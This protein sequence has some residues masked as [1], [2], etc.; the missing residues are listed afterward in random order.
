MGLL[1]PSS[2]SQG[3]P[4]QN[5]AG[6]EERATR[7]SRQP[8]RTSLAGNQI[9]SDF[10]ACCP[11]SPANAA[12]DAQATDPHQTLTCPFRLAFAHSSHLARLC[13]TIGNRLREY[14]S[15]FELTDS[16][17]YSL[18]HAAF[19]EVPMPSKRRIRSP[20]SLRSV[21]GFL[22]HSCSIG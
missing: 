2:R 9:V 1:L 20:P 11:R 4:S 5:R 22:V 12:F 8:P 21:P 13:L 14:F 10:H 18:T 17:L 3:E 15:A 7:P 19:S 6:C 16:G